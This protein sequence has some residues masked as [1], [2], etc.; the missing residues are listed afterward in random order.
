M[1]KKEKKPS[2][3]EKLRELQVVSDL[4]QIATAETIQDMM[5]LPPL[6]RPEKEGRD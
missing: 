1:S 6:I 2:Q 4:Q 5:F 3:E